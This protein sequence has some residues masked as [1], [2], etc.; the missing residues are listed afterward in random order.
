MAVPKKKV[1][2]QRKRL[3]RSHHHLSEP[4]LARCSRC[5]SP[6]RPHAV[7]DACGYYKGVPVLTNAPT[8][9]ESA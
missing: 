4:H 9:S 8:E 3:R 7:C 2:K 5:G 1:S 6:T